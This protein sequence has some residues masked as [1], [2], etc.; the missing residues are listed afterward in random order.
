M[1]T[2]KEWL[3]GERGRSAALARH[4]S[5]QPPN[6]NEWITGKK[7]VPVAHALAIELFTGGAVKRQDL[8]PNEWQKFWPELP[9]PG[10]QQK[11]AA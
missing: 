10:T 4:L 5:L 8:C 9:S 3:K 1:D 2:L 11:A 6:I 7:P